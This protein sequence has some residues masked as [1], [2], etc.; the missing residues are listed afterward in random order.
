MRRTTKCSKGKLLRIKTSQKSSSKSQKWR[1][2]GSR[3]DVTVQL[4]C[5]TTIWSSLVLYRLHREDRLLVHVRVGSSGS[6]RGSRR[7]RDVVRALVKRVDDDKDEEDF[8][9]RG[10]T[11]EST[12]GSS[13]QPRIN[14]L[15]KGKEREHTE[16]ARDL[17]S[18]H[19]R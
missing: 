16:G 18:D 4:E 10:L 17:D 3:I 11:E 5:E 12:V 9:L 15:S 1:D 6:G 2:R 8:L 7:P 19:P 13:S 14:G